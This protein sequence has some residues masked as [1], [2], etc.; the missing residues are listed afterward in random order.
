MAHLLVTQVNN[1]DDNQNVELNNNQVHVETDDED[2]QYAQS[3]SSPSLTQ[4]S[5]WSS[6]FGC[7]KKCFTCAPCCESSEPKQVKPIADALKTPARPKGKWLLPELLDGD[8]G[9]KTLV[10]DLDETLVH[11]SFKPVP[12]A[13]FVI[14]IELENEIHHVYVL[15]RPG[16]DE[17][18]KAVGEKFEVVVF[19]A[20]LAKYA[21]PLLDMLDIHHVVRYRLFRE[22]CVQHYGNYVKDLSLLG[23]DLA[24]TIIIDNSPYSYIFQPDNAV[25]ISS[26]FN[27][28]NDRQLIEIL[29]LLDSMV[30]VDDVVNVLQGRTSF[31]HQQNAISAPQ[32]DDDDA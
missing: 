1:P 31:P 28:Q 27:D 16:V 6:F 15:K 30:D 2:K 18:M 32:Q 5:R 14:S 7:L 20:S 3:S 11:S 13:D 26:W 9:K 25:P 8:R 17:F 10:L 24:S 22:A 21:D 12:N 19:T 23:R 29:P 4:Q